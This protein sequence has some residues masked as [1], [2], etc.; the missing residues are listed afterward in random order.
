M[1][2]WEAPAYQSFQNSNDKRKTTTRYTAYPTCARCALVFQ[3]PPPLRNFLEAAVATSM[4]ASQAGSNGESL[5]PLFFLTVLGV[6]RRRS[7]RM[8]F[9][10]CGT[11]WLQS[12]VCSAL[13]KRD[14]Y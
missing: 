1:R 13:E 7:R 5:R 8:L 12:S 9:S 2:H 6:T 4:D 10:R 11:L 14:V 3:L